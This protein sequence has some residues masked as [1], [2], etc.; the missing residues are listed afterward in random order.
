MRAGSTHAHAHVKLMYVAPFRHRS[1]TAFGPAAGQA[2]V[3]GLLFS[4]PP[5]RADFRGTYH[6]A[7]L[8]AVVVPSAFWFSVYHF[9]WFLWL[10]RRS[11][12]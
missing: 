7:I 5:Y 3:G 9:S 2:G 6:L 1:D 12:A 4:L 10:G 11:V 8:S